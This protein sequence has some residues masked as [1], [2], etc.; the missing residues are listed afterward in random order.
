MPRHFTLVGH[1]GAAYAADQPL[2]TSRFDAARDDA[3]MP[4][5]ALADICGLMP[6]PHDFGKARAMP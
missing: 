3:A 2:A 6:P 1:E 5:N 4:A